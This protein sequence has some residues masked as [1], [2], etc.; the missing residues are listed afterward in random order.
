MAGPRYIADPAED[1]RAV[2]LDGLVALFHA[3]SGMTHIVA[4]PAPQILEALQE[5]PGDARA[6]LARIAALY[7]IEDGNAEA[8]EARLAELE[9]AGL[10]R[11]A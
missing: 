11:R 1:V 10:V 2:P 4:P 3:P 9:A 6:I 7:E 5:G 8:I